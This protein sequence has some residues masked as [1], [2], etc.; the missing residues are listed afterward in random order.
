MLSVCLI[1]GEVGIAKVKLA[2]FA[3]PEGRSSGSKG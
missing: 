3:Y 2:S 1:M